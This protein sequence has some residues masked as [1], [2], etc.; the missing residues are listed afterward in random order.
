VQG[1]A[2]KLVLEG[3]GGFQPTQKADIFNADCQRWVLTHPFIPGRKSFLELTQYRCDD[4]L[5]D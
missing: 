3:D 1:A 4:Q 2:E 5:M